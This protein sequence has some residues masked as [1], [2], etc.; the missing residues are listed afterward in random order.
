MRRLS[1]KAVAKQ[2]TVR[3]LPRTQSGPNERASAT[4]RKERQG[5]RRPDG[6]S[7]QR[8]EREMQRMWTR[9]VVMEGWKD[10]R[11][12]WSETGRRR[13]A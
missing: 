12:E 7:T 13:A 4:A 10:G 1:D 11:T 3:L 2:G 6:R 8:G 9:T 5:E